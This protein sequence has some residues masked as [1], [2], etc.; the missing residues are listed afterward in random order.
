MMKPSVTRTIHN[1]ESMSSL[2]KRPKNPSPIKSRIRTAIVKKAI[3]KIILPKPDMKFKRIV[4][5]VMFLLT[6]KK[7]FQIINFSKALTGG[8][9]AKKTYCMAR[10]TGEKSLSTFVSKVIPWRIMEG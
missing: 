1:L 8:K 7:K 9:R 4:L 5:S 2:V 10:E 6:I 3:L